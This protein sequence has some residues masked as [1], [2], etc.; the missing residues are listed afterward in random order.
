VKKNEKAQYLS[1][2]L[3]NG[4]NCMLV[5][6]MVEKLIIKLEKLRKVPKTLSIRAYNSV[7]SKSDRDIVKNPQL[8][9]NWY[10]ELNA[11]KARVYKRLCVIGAPE[12]KYFD[13]VLCFGDK[14]KFPKGFE[15]NNTLLSVSSTV[16]ISKIEKEFLERAKQYFALEEEIVKLKRTIHNALACSRST[17]QLLKAWPEIEPF[18]VEAYYL[19]KKGDPTPMTNAL[20]PIGAFNSINEKL[21]LK[22]LNPTK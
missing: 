16:E 8:S 18:V 13:F 3:N 15:N 1:K 2:P 11:S 4:D 17:K 6:L 20:V 19:V 14:L 5:K 12:W 10:V 7:F 9:K 21:G 22:S